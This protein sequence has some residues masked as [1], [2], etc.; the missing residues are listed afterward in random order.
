MCFNFELQYWKKIY[1][2]MTFKLLTCP[3]GLLAWQS[4]KDI[5]FLLQIHWELHHSCHFLIPEQMS[6]LYKWLSLFTNTRK[7]SFLVFFDQKQLKRRNGVKSY[8]SSV[9]KK[10]STLCES[11]SH[12]PQEVYPLPL[13]LIP[14][15]SCLRWS[16][17]I[18]GWLGGP[19]RDANEKRRCSAFFYYQMFSYWSQILSI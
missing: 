4:L 16:S 19:I 12:I 3:K 15:S 10:H 1:I 6:Y 11:R 5:F 17:L 2:S 9:S 18:A 8:V 14:R 13:P 7:Y